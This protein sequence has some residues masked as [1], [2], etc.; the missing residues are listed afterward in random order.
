MR[1]RR[2]LKRVG[3]FATAICVNIQLLMYPTIAVNACDSIVNT[4]LTYMDME[5]DLHQERE[6]E[7]TYYGYYDTG[8]NAPVIEETQYLGLSQ[9]IK[10]PSSYSSRDE[11]YVTEVRNQGS[12]GTCWAFGAIA[13]MESYALRHGLVDSPSDI[14]LSEYALASFTFDDGTYTSSTGTAAND[15]TTTDNMK[16]CMLN[17]GNDQYVFKTLTKWAGIMNESDY[18][19]VWAGTTESIYDKTKVSYVL[20][21]QYFI[22]MNNMWHVKNAIMENGAVTAH[23]NANDEYDTDIWYKNYHYTYEE[24]GTNHAIAIVGWDDSIDAS[25]FTVVDDKGNEHTPEGPGAW[26]IKNSWGTSY[27]DMG[28]MWVSYYD[29]SMKDSTCVVYQIAPRSQY[30]YNYQHDGGTIIGINYNFES[31]SYANV[32][33]VAGNNKQAIKAISFGIEDVN[34][35]YS[36][37][38]YKNPST[39]KPESGMAMLE[40]PVKGVATYAGYHT[41]DLPQMIELEVGNSFSVVITFDQK[42]HLTSGYNGSVYVGGGGYA[43]ATNESGDNQSYM[44]ENGV[45]YDMYECYGSSYK[46]NFCIKA[47]L[48]DCGDEIEA[49]TITSIEKNG[50]TGFIIGWQAVKNGVVYEL[51]RATSMDGEYTVAYSGTNTS[52]VDTSV[53]KYTRYYYKIR[54]YDGQLPLD[55]GVRAAYIGVENAKIKDISSVRDGLKLQWNKA[56]NVNGYNLYRSLNGIDYELM[57]TVG[58]VNSYVDENVEYGKRYYYVV[59]SYVNIIDGSG[60]TNIEEAVDNIAMSVIR[61]INTPSYI[62]AYMDEYEYGKVNLEWSSA[63]DVDG[64]LLYRSYFDREGKYVEMEE[65]ASVVG[66]NLTYVADV[67]DIS[68]G[69]NIYF[70]V[71]AYMNV[72]GDKYMS[73]YS[74]VDVYLDYAPV[75]NIK[76]YVNS[77]GVLNVKWDEYSAIG[78]TVTGYTAFVYNDLAGTSFATSVTSTT[79][80]FARASLDTSKQYYVYIQAKNA[81]NNAFTPKQKPLVQI[82]GAWGEFAFENIKDVTGEAG[83]KVTLEAKLTYEL[84]NFDYHYQWYRSSSKDGTGAAIPGATTSA[85]I[86]ELKDEGKE[87]YYCICTGEYKG[88]KTITSNSVEVSV[89][90]DEYIDNSYTGLIKY[91]NAW[92]YVKEGK[93]DLTYT[94][95][96]KNEYGWWYVKN[97]KLDRTYTGL[98][99]NEYGWWYVEN[100]KV[101]RTYTGMAKNEYGWWYVKAGK[102]DLNYTGLGTNQYGTWYMVDGKVASN[103]SGLTKVS[104]IWMY[105]TKGKVDTSFTGLAKNANGWWYVTN[106]QVDFSYTGMAKNSYGWWY[107]TDGKL[108]RTFTGIS[109]NQYGKWYLKNGEVDFS[110]TGTVKYNDVVYNIKNGKVV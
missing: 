69:Q 11:G 8:Y 97:G 21:N 60:A 9:A 19:Y 73:D 61:D 88:T 99:K 68:P 34:R 43:I 65:V 105:L 87:Y 108:D 79:P 95:L 30:D 67:T 50:D 56:S 27:G 82:G 71:K 53:N 57:A 70:Y 36:I 22:N 62:D 100:G 31:S 77:S 2:P 54:V 80:N 84:E 66:N 109:A 101:D 1:K 5:A 14:D 78:I 89:K 106:G 41:V 6:T 33:E 96:A 102:V 94:G 26:L 44:K 103:L 10:L 28:Y 58:D 16:T 76:W 63:G 72:N 4:P 75:Q 25:N 98:G 51:L 49:S 42:T 64:Y 32:Y 35:E 17:G 55:S 15:R 104:K 90:S 92:W 29:K 3:A 83:Q 110:Y 40:S 85:Y 93:L 23:Y 13:A 107:V 86:V 38:I 46:V 45:F 91:E 59:K 47:M 74:Y 7:D 48:V 52:Y 12:L 39:D 81:M 24:V 37:Q 20:T 18:P